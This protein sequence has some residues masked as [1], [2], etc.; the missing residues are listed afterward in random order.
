MD[1]LIEKMAEVQ[2]ENYQDKL[3]RDLKGAQR[4]PWISDSTKAL[5]VV[6][7]D[8]KQHSEKYVK[9]CDCLHAVN[10]QGELMSVLK[11]N[12]QECHGKGIVSVEVK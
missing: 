5:S 6:L 3:W 10:I 1:E 8:I 7:A 4:H 12:C 11:A 2:Y 9:L